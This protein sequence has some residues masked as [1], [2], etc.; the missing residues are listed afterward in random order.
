MR[1]YKAFS[2][3]ASIKL[4]PVHKRTRMYCVLSDLLFTEPNS[5]NDPEL[6]DVILIN[7]HKITLTVT[8][9]N[10]F[11]TQKKIRRASGSLHFILLDWEVIKK[12][13]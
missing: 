3:L 9:V 6:L 11:H 10:E 4:N 12:V 2:N 7:L 8:F 5:G 1:L 13:I